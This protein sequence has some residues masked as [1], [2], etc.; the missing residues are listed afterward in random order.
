MT[1]EGENDKKIRV[2]HHFFQSCHGKGPSD[3]EG[4]VVKSC[5]HDG[6]FLYDKYFADTE[7][8]YKYLISSSGRVIHDKESS[9]NEQERKARGQVGVGK[10]G[11]TPQRSQLGLTT[12]SLP[13]AAWIGSL[14]AAS[15]LLQCG[16]N[17]LMA[18]AARERFLC[19]EI[20]MHPHLG[21]GA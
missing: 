12:P 18:A 14:S 6:E 10:R 4:A 2:S 17:T 1:E 3:S 19:T 15:I 5:L 8:A 11:T 20:V 7:A 13:Q 9:E 21:G 16:V